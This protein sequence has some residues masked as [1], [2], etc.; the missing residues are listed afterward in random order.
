MIVRITNK[1]KSNQLFKDS[2]WSLLGN[3][4]GRGLSLIAGIIIAR[5]LGKDVYGEYG[6]IRNTI[7]TIGVF[8]TFG[9]GY[10]STKFIAE[11]RQGAKDKIP[12]FIKYANRITLLFSGLMAMLLFSFSNFVAVEWLKAEHLASSLR[13]L[14][15][16]IIFNA[17]TTTQIGVLSGFGLFKAIAKINSY[18]GALTF[19]LSVL[20]T[21]LYSLNGA[22]MA[23]LIV[24]IVNCIINYKLVRKFIPYEKDVV[25]NRSMLK[26]IISFSTPIALQEAVY[27]IASWVSSILLIHYSSYGDLGMYSAAMQWNAIIL[28]I[29]GI[30]RNVILSHLSVAS[31]DLQTHSRILRHTILI[32]SIS[33]LVP[34]IIVFFGS[35][36]IS[37]IYGNSFVGLNTIISIAVFSTVFTSISNVYAQA[38]TSLGKNWHM[39]FIRLLRD[40]F[41]LLSFVLLIKVAGMTGSMSMVISNLVIG[42]IFVILIVMI[43]N[44]LNKKNVENKL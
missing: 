16:L 2:F 7:L 20:L 12:V 36:L 22:L 10:T 13:I 42:V 26:E 14:S 4:I 17:I 33:T 1:L 31:N 32:N 27:S 29:P 43:F 18:I 3:I 30:L 5:L 21:Y 9:L 44:K 41:V 38:F 19:L 8:S 28:F 39:F 37:K 23:L 15:V 11:F 6:V 24:Q 40:T 35:S 25:N 34:T